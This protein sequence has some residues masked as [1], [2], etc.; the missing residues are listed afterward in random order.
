[1]AS[2]PAAPVSNQP[3]SE[4]APLLA[5][6]IWAGDL[7]F[8]ARSGHASMVLDGDGEAGP[9]PM[10]SLAFA[11]AGCMGMDIV[12]I[13][14]KSRVPATAVRMSLSGRRPAGNPGRFVAIDM[15]VDLDGPASD[16]QVQRAIDLS[17]ST[18][19]SVWNSMSQDIALNV[20][21][22]VHRPPL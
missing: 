15:H 2:E 5:E 16:D 12:H 13:L 20:T 9:S 14:K 22:T 10:Q 11:F 7:R 1:M 17:R 19:C 3:A 8:S 21:F 4:R 18:Y 6:L